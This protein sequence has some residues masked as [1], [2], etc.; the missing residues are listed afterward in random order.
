MRGK[1]EIA[2]RG[3]TPCSFL[4]PLAGRRPAQ[5]QG[6]RRAYT[7][8]GRTA[9]AD[10]ARRAAESRKEQHLAG[11]AWPACF[12]ASSKR[13]PIGSSLSN[14]RAP[15]SRSRSKWDAAVLWN[16]WRLINNTSLYDL[17][18]DPGQTTNVIASYPDVVAQMRSH[19]EAWWA[20]VAPTVNTFS[21]ITIGSDTAN[22]VLLRP[23]EWRNFF[24]GPRLRS[25][26]TG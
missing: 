9:D 14:T 6:H 11:S 16:R 3:R 20:G 19:Y 23:P 22:P 18:T 2:L 24:P 25:Y 8:T 12:A 4:Y 5:S 7:G 17:S 1:K 15:I 21:R 26:R 10:R 13:F